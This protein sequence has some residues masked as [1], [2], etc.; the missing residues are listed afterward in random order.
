MTGEH[1]HKLSLRASELTLTDKL[2]SLPANPGV[3]QFKNADG[4][5]IYVGKAQ[6]LRSRVRQY[7]QKSRTA[8]PK[9][10][11]MVEKIA[12]VE[13]IVTDSEIE[14]LILEANLIKKLKPR[15]NVILKDDKSYPYIVITNEPFPRVFVTRRVIRDGSRYFGPYADVKNVRFALKTVRDI[16]MIR[17]CNY[18]ITDD[19]IRKKKFKIC[20]DYHIKKCEGP[21]E[22]IVSAEHYKR[23]IDQVASVLKGKSDSVVKA[24]EHDMQRLSDEMR[25]EDAARVRDSIRALYVYSEKQKVVDA[26]QVDRD[27]FA[28]AVKGDDAAGVIFR[29]RD[30]KL[31][32]SRHFYMGNAEGKPESELVEH[33]IERY[34]L[35]E[36]DI[37]GELFLPTGLESESL[38][39]S[40]LETRRGGAVSIE[41]PKA[42]EK[43]KLVSMARNNA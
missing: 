31:V 19:A 1:E 8:D 5:V 33:L 32:G 11:V 9:I 4:K 3:Y 37:P 43:A 21:C 36:E 29:I 26:K 2:E 23:M 20:L 24:L 28:V 7:F 38:V 18:D 17:S 25:F 16:F 30:G 10:D 34:Y 41:I 13:L 12:D 27:I 40:W 35:E 6:N 14:A 22:G 42:G 39:Q 15:Y